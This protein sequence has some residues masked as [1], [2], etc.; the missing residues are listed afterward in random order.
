M[1]DNRLKS[2]ELFSKNREKK[3]IDLGEQVIFCHINLKNT[4]LINRL[5]SV[6]ASYLNFQ[7]ILS[8]DSK[9]TEILDIQNFSEYS[10][11]IYAISQDVNLDRLKDFVDL[12]VIFFDNEDDIIESRLDLDYFR[13]PTVVINTPI[14]YFCRD[15][16]DRDLLNDPQIYLVSE[17]PNPEL[18]SLLIKRFFA[19]NK[20]N[21]SEP[22]PMLDVPNPATNNSKKVT[23]SPRKKMIEESAVV[24]PATHAVGLQ[25]EGDLNGAIKYYDRALKQN[26]QQQ[27]WVFDSFAECLTAEGKHQQAS[28]IVHTGLKL[29]PEAASL[30]RFLG[31]IQDR[32]GNIDRVIVNYERAI[33]LDENQP[34]WVYC[35]LAD[36]Y[37]RQ[38]KLEESIRIAFGGIKLYPQRA[39]VYRSL[40]VIQDRQGRITETIESYQKAI[41]LDSQQPFWVYCALIERLNSE[42]RSQ[43][44]VEVGHQGI[45]QYPQQP[46]IY[47]HL[48]AAQDQQSDLVGMTQSY[49]RAVKLNP[50][51]PVHLY[52]TL[53]ESLLAQNELNDAIELVT[54]ASKLYP[55]QIDSLRSCYHKVLE[56]RAD[57]LSLYQDPSP[58]F[59]GASRDWRSSCGLS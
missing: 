43:E 55:E 9:Q 22:S 8:I 49:Q 18:F 19:T 47:F 59:T 44:A 23:I 15:S 34:F 5:L 58:S 3:G 20:N 57:D 11:N 4:N 31:V 40:G 38:G 1:K 48:G 25:K 33:A 30:Y 42:A 41:A 56:I 29:Y 37:Q 17:Q 24:D 12:S 21:H 13:D 52:L 46:E 32:K 51:Q 10:D 50:Q 6:M 36:Y 54:N 27:L 28:E 35:V 7:F 26:P 39:D 53:I 16:K 45:K 14:L 2:A